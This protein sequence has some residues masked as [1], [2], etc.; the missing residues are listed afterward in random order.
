[1]LPSWILQ[2]LKLIVS[3]ITSNNKEPYLPSIPKHFNLLP[4]SVGSHLLIMSKQCSLPTLESWASRKQKNIQR[5]C[6][7]LQMHLQ[8][9]RKLDSSR[10][11]VQD[12]LSQQNRMHTIHHSRRSVYMYDTLPLVQLPGKAVNHLLLENHYCLY[13]YNIKEINRS[14]SENRREAAWPSSQSARLE[15]R[16]SQVQISWCCSQGRPNLNLT[17]FR[18]T[19][20]SNQQS[21]HT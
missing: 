10:L 8:D 4:S 18:Y 17:L 19:T 5:D 13:T 16:R 14:M 20:N 7:L 11:Q 15:T 6:L 1:M 21:K 9:I 3:R 12:I 2:D